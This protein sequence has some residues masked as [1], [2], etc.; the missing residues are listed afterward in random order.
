M[1][2]DIFD[3]WNR[4]AR[5]SF[6]HPDDS[7]V[8]A[9][10]DHHF[11]LN[12]LPAPF[13]G[14]LK[15]AKIVLLFLAPGLGRDGFD[16]KHAETDSGKDWYATQLSGFA[17]LPG[18]LQHKPHF[19]WWTSKAKQLGIPT[20]WAANNLA[21]LDLAPYHSA[22]FHDAR[23]LAALP[24]VRVCVGWAQ[25]VLFPQ[26][27]AG[28]RMVLCLR[29]PEFWGL[30]RGSVEGRALYSPDVTRGGHMLHGVLRKMVAA[31]ALA[32]SR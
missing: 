14:P 29:S 7:K 28:E 8:L 24:S 15:T 5:G 16:R 18:P 25:R 30:K 19:Q 6:V 2:E 9:R 20:E 31:E 4:C 21:V 22:S 17:P 1:N 27:I 3:F 23:F 26:A 32:L 13:T 11:D 12:C 10:I